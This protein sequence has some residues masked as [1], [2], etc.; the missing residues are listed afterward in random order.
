MWILAGRGRNTYSFHHSAYV[1]L[2]S[3]LYVSIPVASSPY[4]HLLLFKKKKK[5]RAIIIVCYLLVA[6]ICISVMTNNVEH[7][8]MYLF[9]IYISS[10]VKCQFKSFPHFKYFVFSVLSFEDS[11]YILDINPSSSC[12]YFS[13]FVACLFIFL[14]VFFHRTEF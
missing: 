1:M 9:S 13:Q 3:H 10:L 8:F 11:L 4:Q 12:K 7:P 14:T 6:W 2:H 5:G